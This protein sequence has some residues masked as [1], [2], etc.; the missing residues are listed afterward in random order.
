MRK[1]KQD[2]VNR[3]KWIIGCPVAIG[4]IAFVV[5]S[6][7]PHVWKSFGFENSVDVS[8]DADKK[9]L[10]KAVVARACNTNETHCL[11]DVLLVLGEFDEG[12]RESINRL[13]KE[14]SGKPFKTVCLHSRGGDM[15]FA[16]D[17]G[18]WI[19]NHDFD[20]C[21]ADRYLLAD[22]LTLINTECD[23]A[24]PW[25]L[26]AG[27]NRI[28]FGESFSIEV[29]HPG[30]TLSVCFCEMKI[31]S[32]ADW[33]HLDLVEDMLN[34]KPSKD[35][36]DHLKLFERSQETHHSESDLIEVAEWEK[37]SI[38]TDKRI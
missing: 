15:R 20:T 18:E 32:Y 13:L 37:Y 21:L 5:C 16:A 36:E 23:S 29:H 30:G 35:L 2:K 6:L 24:C 10:P 27:L 19:K 7:S 14:R 9:Q 3:L 1:L 8:V 4:V 26:L 17:I 25:V 33:E 34:Y 22:G 38:F 31:N 28:Q 12:T 11:D